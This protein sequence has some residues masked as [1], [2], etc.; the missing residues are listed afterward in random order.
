MVGLFFLG[1]V[2]VTLFFS[3]LRY[4]VFCTALLLL[5]T[6]S[7]VYWL[8]ELAGTLRWLF[9]GAIGA[10]GFSQWILGK[11]PT[12]FRPIDLWMVGFLVLAFY[13]LTYSILPS[14]TLQRAVSLL[15][16]YL[17]VFWG[18]WIYVED[19]KKIAIVIHQ[20]LAAS[21]IV[22]LFGL[23]NIGAGGRFS[24]FFTSPNTVGV[25]ASVLMPLVFWSALCKKNRLSFALLFLMG[26]S[27]LLSMSRGGILAA[28]IGVGYFLV[29]YYRRHRAAVVMLLL[30]FIG[31]SYFYVEMFGAASIK[32]YLRWDTLLSGSGR[33]EAWTE[34]MRLVKMRPWFG[35]GF[36]TEDFLF[37]RFDIRLS[38]R[39][40]V[41]MAHNQL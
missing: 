36:G 1:F 41:L 13:S 22:F 14:V 16:F 12:R 23:T 7:S 20:L 5:L 31:V 8:S 11:S 21:F 4:L 17:A 18:V 30:F 6:S 33:S 39:E 32:D 37:E 24:S 40:Y 38:L 19:E 34:V 25:L 3:D 35:Y 2:L 28:M 9:L 29:I 27:L 15:I 10:V 26:V